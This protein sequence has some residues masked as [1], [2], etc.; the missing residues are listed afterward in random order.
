MRGKRREFAPE[1][2]Q[3]QSR[4]RRQVA[5]SDSSD[6][7]EAFKS[8]AGKATS[9]HK[10]AC[11]RVPE[12]IQVDDK[13]TMNLGTTFT[14][15]P[16]TGELTDG[17]QLL[18]NPIQGT[19]AEVD[20]AINAVTPGRYVSPYVEPLNA[21]TIVIDSSVIAGKVKDVIKSLPGGDVAVKDIDWSFFARQEPLVYCEQTDW[22]L[23]LS[24]DKKM[25][26]I[27]TFFAPMP[28]IS[29]P[30]LGF[31]P[32]VYGNDWKYVKKCKDESEVQ[33][34]IKKVKKVCAEWGWTFNM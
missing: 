18:I 6:L 19:N 17:R 26:S 12:A 23:R 33:K 11:E 22:E 30:N 28:G 2:V 32:P 14:K 7:D 8:S 16:K 25:R 13:S 34:T 24:G 29:N 9:F 15:N 27:G 21:K 10:K 31:D 5:D 4:R 1:T 3:K 20:Q